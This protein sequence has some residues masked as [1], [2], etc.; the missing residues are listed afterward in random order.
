MEDVLWRKYFERIQSSTSLDALPLPLD[1]FLFY[2]RALYRIGFLSAERTKALESIGFRF[3]FHAKTE[4]DREW[5]R[6]LS[7]F[8]K[9]KMHPTQVQVIHSYLWAPLPSVGYRRTRLTVLESGSIVKRRGSPLCRLYEPC[10][11]GCSKTRSRCDGWMDAFQMLVD[12]VIPNGIGHRCVSSQTVVGPQCHTIFFT[13][14]SSTRFRM[15]DRRW[16]ARRVLPH[17]N[18]TPSWQAPSVFAC[19]RSS[20]RPVLCLDPSP[21]RLGRNRN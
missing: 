9:R 19:L 13:R 17:A 4:D 15:S 8:F 1:V 7:F 18:R 2:Q 6:R 20:C 11:S 10:S 16:A 21:L 14:C 3:A 12:P 5:D